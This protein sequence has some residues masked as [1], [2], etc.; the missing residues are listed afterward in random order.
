[1]H[2]GKTKSNKL[3]NCFHLKPPRSIGDLFKATYEAVV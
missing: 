2:A 3:A 1:M